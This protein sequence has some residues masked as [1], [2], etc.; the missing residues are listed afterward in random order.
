M[1]IDATETSADRYIRLAAELR[2][3]SNE[4]KAAADAEPLWCIGRRD[5][6]R[7]QVFRRAAEAAEY[8]Y[9]IALQSNPA[10]L[11]PIRGE[12]LLPKLQQT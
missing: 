4:C 11:S 12:S 8:A 5:R 7:P 9:L 2:K 3:V 1:E 6:E 10:E